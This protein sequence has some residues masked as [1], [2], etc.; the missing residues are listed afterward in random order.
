MAS[1]EK[2]KMRVEFDDDGL[3]K[4]VRPHRQYFGKDPK[5]FPAELD[6]GEDESIWAALC[7]DSE[8][9]PGRSVRVVEVPGLVLTAEPE[10]FGSEADRRAAGKMVFNRM[11]FG[12]WC[13]L[14]DMPT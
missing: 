3:F 5:A 12:Q 8:G 11:Q 2:W 7:D 13:L 9:C 4:M 14:G 10:Q 6:F 1:Q